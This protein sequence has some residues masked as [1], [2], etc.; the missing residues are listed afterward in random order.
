MCGIVGY[1]GGRTATQVLLPGLKRLEYRGYDS[2][3]IAVLNGSSLTI[4]KAQGK[5]AELEA[6]L[7]E[8]PVPG[9]VG[10]AHTRWATHG[11]PSD[12]NAHPH[13]DCT[14][15]VAVVHNGIIENH[16]ELRARLLADGHR[17]VSETDT[18]VLS[19]M[20]E[21]RVNGSLETAVA[22][23]LGEIEGSSAVAVVDRHFP[24]RLI[25]ARVGGSPLIIGV[26]DGEYLLAS[27]IPAILPFTRDVVVL[28]DGEMAVMTRGG[29]QIRRI[30]GE[31]V[32]CRTQRID[33]TEE[34]AEKSGFPHFMLKEIYEQPE[35]VDATLRGRIDPTSGLPCLPEI[36]LTRDTLRRVRR[37]VLVACGTSWHAALVGKFL[38]EEWAG[39]P[40][41]VDIASEFRYRHLLVNDRTL[42]IPIS[43]S[44]ETADTLAALREAQHRKAR[45]ISICNVVGSSVGREAEGVLYTRAGIEIGVA[46]TKAFT[47]QLA[48]LYLL[49]IHVGLMLDRLPAAQARIL[50][51]HLR[52]VPE[53]LQRILARAEDVAA[54]AASYTSSSDFL[55]LARG[56]HF[57]IA[58]EGA[59]KLKEISYI[60]AEGYPAG[61]MKHGP[62]ALI[63]ARMPVVVLAPLGRTYEKVLSN[64]AEVKARNGQVIALVSEG[65]TGL[66]GVADHLLY[67]PYVSE[68]VAPIFETVPLQLLAYYIAVAR[69]CDVDQPRNLAKSV[70]VE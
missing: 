47:T 63:D 38:I 65:E 10:I 42:V 22:S 59:L 46:S 1:V 33:W 43:Q 62:I 2:S 54:V 56:I 49:A 24:D 16:R 67:F 30:S 27:D 35:A 61:E 12:R 48:S 19:H 7:T 70:T 8:A 28:G 50:L 45:V 29:I 68:Y 13:P 39:V 52:R 60:H 51:E 9:T 4:R 55:Y 23:S 20:I 31:P 32:P 3:G 53:S 5:I 18:E 11:V 64:I 41:E 34:A 37:V 66:S 36:P 69:G 58:L 15:S 21:Q 25:A 44:G 40:C 57:P 6:R 17:L 26:G 14:E